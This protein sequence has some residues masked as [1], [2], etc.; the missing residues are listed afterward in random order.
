M[1]SKEKK[2]LVKKKD[3]TQFQE[4]MTA[5]DREIIQNLCKFIKYNQRLLHVDLSHTNMTR[6]MLYE[7]GPALRRSKSMI[8]L[9]LSG[10]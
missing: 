4:E 1:W 9:H 10:N 2:L 7:F 8:A 3:I 6:M 5:N